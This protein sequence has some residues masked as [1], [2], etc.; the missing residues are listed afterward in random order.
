M[1]EPLHQNVVARIMS[2]IG[3]AFAYIVMTLFAVMTVAPIVWLIINS[4]K[5]TQE[6]RANRIALPHVWTMVNY[7]GA[8][9]L[10]EFDKLIGNSVIYT[11]GATLGIIF[12]SILAGFAFAKIKNRATPILYGSFVLG[13]L[14]SIQ[15]LMVPL[16]IE[17]SQLDSILTGL[18]KTL[19]IM[20]S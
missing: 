18:L 7:P 19:G 20:K 4:F 17:V 13:I 1:A 9:R 16:F 14:L 3:R 12:F 2:G 5:S 8:W 6:F 10:G 11:L 15:S